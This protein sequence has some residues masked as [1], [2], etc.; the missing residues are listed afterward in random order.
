MLKLFQRVLIDRG[1]PEKWKTTL[2]VIIHKRTTDVMKCQSYTD[3]KTKQYAM[4]IA[5]K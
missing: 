1:T 4:K 2:V 5:E 3:V